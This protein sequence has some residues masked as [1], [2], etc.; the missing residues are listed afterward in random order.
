MAKINPKINVS[1][2]S[3][4]AVKTSGRDRTPVEF[5]LETTH[6]Y[7]GHTPSRRAALSV[8]GPSGIIVGTSGSW[9]AYAEVH[10]EVHAPPVVKPK[11]RSR[12]RITPK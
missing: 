9:R 8:A 2:Q 11:A 3:R 12:A 1:P 5:E 10:A 6:R 7:V 4:A